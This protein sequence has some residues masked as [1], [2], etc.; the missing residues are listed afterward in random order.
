MCV[1]A[2]VRAYLPTTPH[3]ISYPLRIPQTHALSVQCTSCVSVCTRVC[4]FATC[5]PHSP[6]SLLNPIPSRS[7]STCTERRVSLK[8]LCAA[9]KQRVRQLVEELARVTAEKEK[10][11]GRLTK[12][13]RRFER[14]L[15]QME[16]ERQ[17]AM[18]ERAHILL[19]HTSEHATH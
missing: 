10:V 12:E 4:T 2:C 9:D 17:S 13:R 5:L 1:R 11:E 6:L 16:Q 7:L 8:D 18:Q 14:A 19:T 3:H 15:Q